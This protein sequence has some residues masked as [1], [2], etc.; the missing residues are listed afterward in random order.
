MTIPSQ[1]LK[2]CSK[3]GQEKLFSCYYVRKDKSR[4]AECKECTK[5][6]RYKY[7]HSSKH[8]EIRKRDNAAKARFRNRIKDAVFAAYGGYK[9][10]CCGET[11]KAF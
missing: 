3:C 8:E 4:L 5:A 6:R 11:E 7:V 9:C 10:V 1:D 2:K